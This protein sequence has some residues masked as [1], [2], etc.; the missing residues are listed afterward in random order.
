MTGKKKYNKNLWRFFLGVF[1]K[2]GFVFFFACQSCQ[3]TRNLLR[4]NGLLLTGTLTPQPVS[5]VAC[6]SALLLTLDALLNTPGTVDD[7]P[8]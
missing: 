6:L 8:Y 1:A 5:R 3:H 4:P 2:N 7:R